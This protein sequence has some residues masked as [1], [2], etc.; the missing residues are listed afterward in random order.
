M[1][2]TEGRGAIDSRMQIE[3]R[4]R[5]DFQPKSQGTIC[6]KAG[7]FKGF[8]RRSLLCLD[9]EAP[10]P[11]DPRRGLSKLSRYVIGVF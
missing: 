2:D 4:V 10:I 11:N 6:G 1:R 3:G 7:V 5:G 8:E 9:K